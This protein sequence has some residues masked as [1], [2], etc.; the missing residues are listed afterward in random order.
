M[1]KITPMLW[2][3]TEAEEAAKLYVSVFPDSNIEETTHYGPEFPDQKGRVMTV[4]F[5]LFGQRFTALNGGPEFKFNESVSFVVACETQE[6]ID[7][8]WDKLTDGGEES[9]CGWLKDRFGVSWQIVPTIL[10]ELLS[11]GGPE[12]ASRVTKAFLPMKKLDIK[13]LLDAAKG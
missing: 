3:D 4:G 1:E 8:Y 10:S 2:F 11:S 9:Q 6:E 12:Q 13:V 7:E 5:R